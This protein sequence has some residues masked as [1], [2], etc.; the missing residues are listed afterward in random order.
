MSR[1]NKRV[2]IVDDE[3]DLGL[4]LK[5]ILERNGFSA[6]YYTN[7][8]IAL[9]NFKSGCYDLVILDIKMPDING[10]E[11][12][13]CF[14]SIDTEIKTLFLSAV[15]SLERYNVKPKVQPKE[16]ETYFAR[17]PIKN[18]DLLKIVNSMTN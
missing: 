11:L 18:Q 1:V 16:G 14:K 10:F 2:L 8:V 6:D 7:P 5:I 15:T 9:K 3:E 12:Y 13:T 17:K 4:T